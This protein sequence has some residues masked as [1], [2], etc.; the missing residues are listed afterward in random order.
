MAEKTATRKELFARI[1]EFMN[2]DPEVVEMCEKYIKQLETPRKK[3][4]NTESLEFAEKVYAELAKM[5]APVTN[6]EMAA[7][8]TEVLGTPIHTQKTAYALKRLVEGDRVIRVVAEK[9]T[10]KDTFVLA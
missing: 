6:G 3:K 8:M 5:D 7:H 9:K 4:A 1:A 10:E 2:D